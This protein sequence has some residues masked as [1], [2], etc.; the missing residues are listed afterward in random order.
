[1]P[2]GLEVVGLCKTYGPLTVLDGVHLHLEAGESVAVLGASGS[3][4][5]TLLRCIVRLEEPDGGRVWIGGEEI[6]ARGCDLDRIRSRAALV[7][8]QYS[9]F[10]HLNAVDNCAL[11]L[12]A[13]RGLRRGDA[14]ARARSALEELGVGDRLRA[15]PHELSGGQQ[16][17]VAIARALV[18]EPRL[19][20]LDEPT[21][22]L[23]PE[24]IHALT[25]IVRGLAARGVSFLIVTHEVGFARCASD[26]ILH[27]KAGRVAPSLR[28]GTGG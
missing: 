7:Y 5:T 21:S 4:K 18:M 25:G 3:G 8:Q 27:L 13:V 19:M 10:P 15:F 2:N 9:L 6:T 14:D 11:A 17:R 24:R 16:Q 28:A 20:M 23:D 22:A 26:R 12:R 1:M